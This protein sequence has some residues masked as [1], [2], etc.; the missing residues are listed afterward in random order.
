MARDPFPSIIIIIAP[1]A[2]MKGGPSP[3]IIRNPGITII[4][5]YPVPA[6]GIRS[7]SVFGIRDPN[8]TISRVINPSTIGIKFVIEL[9]IRNIFSFLCPDFIWSGEHY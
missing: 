6:C 7:E 4:C 8:V 3:G 2:I 9:L 1:A 5:H